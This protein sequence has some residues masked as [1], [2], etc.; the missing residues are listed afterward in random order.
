MSCDFVR[1]ILQSEKAN[2]MTGAFSL[3]VEV[4][5]PKNE[6]LEH[7]ND[8]DSRSCWKLERENGSEFLCVA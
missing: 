2:F 7:V 1:I 5:Q 8:R 4:D 3:K 6:G